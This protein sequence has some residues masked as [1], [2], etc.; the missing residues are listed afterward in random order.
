MTGPTG[1]CVVSPQTSGQAR[2]IDQHGQLIRDLTLDP[3]RNYQAL[4]PR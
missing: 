1:C 2:V 3:S 4:R